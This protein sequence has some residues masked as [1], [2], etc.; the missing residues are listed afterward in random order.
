MTWNPGKNDKALMK[1]FLVFKTIVDCLWYLKETIYT[2]NEL[3][4]T[5][6]N[7]FLSNRNEMTEVENICCK[8]LAIVGFFF[9]IATPRFYAARHG[10]NIMN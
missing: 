9:V 2:C 1:D 4:V 6:L 7:K 10:R 8:V 5:N 3:I